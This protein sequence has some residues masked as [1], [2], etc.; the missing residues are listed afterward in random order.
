MGNDD[1]KLIDFHQRYLANLNKRQ[2]LIKRGLIGTEEYNKLEIEGVELSN[3]ARGLNRYYKNRPVY[4]KYK[5]L[6]KIIS[7]A[8]GIPVIPIKL[9]K[10]KQK[11]N[12]KS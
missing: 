10:E 3:Q 9:N 8:V 6:F 12:L 2:N 11:K 4:E 7:S 1:K 5:S